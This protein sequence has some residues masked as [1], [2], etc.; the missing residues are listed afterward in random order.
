MPFPTLWYVSDSEPFSIFESD[1]I[2][3]FSS[4]SLATLWL[5]SFMGFSS[6][7][8]EAS[9]GNDSSSYTSDN[10]S[11]L[12]WFSNFTDSV[13]L[14]SESSSKESACLVVFPHVVRSSDL[15]SW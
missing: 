14:V 2:G 11:P 10:S 6:L 15:A 1:N 4:W 5:S 13:G 9:L 7:V 3:D 12:V 8:V